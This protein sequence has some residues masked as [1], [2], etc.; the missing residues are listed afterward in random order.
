M[1]EFIDSG[2]H[3]KEQVLIWRRSYDIPP[4]PCDTDSPYYPVNDP[5]YAK[6]PHESL[7]FSESLADTEKRF[8]VEWCA[9]IAP[10]SGIF[11]GRLGQ[12]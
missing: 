7:P 9:E 12:S 8:M 6:I 4:P 10:E 3:G 2:M 11:L 1:E 5:T